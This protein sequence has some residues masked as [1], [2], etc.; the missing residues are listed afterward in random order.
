MFGENLMQLDPKKRR[1]IENGIYR[2]TRSIFYVQSKK[3]TS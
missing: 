3:E 2:R 1:I